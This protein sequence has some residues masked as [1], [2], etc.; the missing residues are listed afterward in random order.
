LLDLDTLEKEYMNMLATADGRQSE[1]DQQTKALKKAHASSMKN[2]QQEKDTLTAK[3]Q[4]AAAAA[5]EAASRAQK[6][7]VA[8][9]TKA[10]KALKAATVKAQ[11]AVATAEKDAART[12][13]EA[14]TALA[15]AKK[16]ASTAAAKAKQAVKT[17][18]AAT[19]AAM[20][21]VSTAK[22][23][24]AKAAMQVLAEKKDLQ[25]KVVAL[26]N[27]LKQIQ[28]KQTV[29]LSNLKKANKEH[30]ACKKEIAVVQKYHS[31]VMKASTTKQSNKDDEMKV[32]QQTHDGNVKKYN[33]LNKKC[34]ETA[35]A[36]TT[37]QKKTKTLQQSQEDGV[38]K[39][40]QAA[41]AARAL[42]ALNKKCQQAV[43]AANAVKKEAEEAAKRAEDALKTAQQG[44]QGHQD[45]ATTLGETLRALKQE[46]KQTVRQQD[47]DCEKRIAALK[48]QSLLDL[49][50][51]EKQYINMVATSDG[52]QSE[53]DDKMELLV[54]SHREKMLKL[55][56][57]NKVMNTKCETAAVAAKKAI[58]LE[59]KMEQKQ[60]LLDRLKTQ[61]QTS[62]NK[63]EQKYMR[64]VEA[65]QTTCSSATLK[66]DGRCQ[67]QINRLQKRLGIATAKMADCIPG[68]C[69]GVV[70]LLFVV[71][72]SLFGVEKKAAS[73]PVLL[74]VF[75]SCYGLL[76]CLYRHVYLN[77][78]GWSAVPIPKDQ[79][80]Q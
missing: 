15:M 3:C 58:A 53:F 74:C 40:Q 71:C 7:S 20:T 72:Y 29:S 18:E 59:K 45:Q 39:L 33:D 48:K 23:A 79:N 17:A 19:T 65:S 44:S 57:D 62:M 24:A 60:I 21:E 49:D 75:F 66:N 68:R 12:T 69:G 32:L 13:K 6:D 4:L 30:A 31:N 51:L 46:H 22:K 80:D 56:Q 37:A 16:E 54:V 25:M 11:N 2:L 61:H 43:V 73:H 38:N 34:Q 28:G 1:F 70:A 77:V 47:S 8:A 14:V 55:N 76:L 35:R 42:D 5:S 26:E 10:D 64:M 27:D 52:K 36:L 78:T 67:D 41:V 9:A 63:M 50:T